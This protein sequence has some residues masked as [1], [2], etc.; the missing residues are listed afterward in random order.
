[1]SCGLH[2]NR[3]QVLRQHNLLFR[4]W[5]HIPLLQLGQGGA[6]SMKHWMLNVM[7]LWLAVL[8]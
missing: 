1:M 3:K 2:Q 8:P 7:G 5:T 4:L 6:F